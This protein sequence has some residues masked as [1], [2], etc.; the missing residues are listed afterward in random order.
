MARPEP[1]AALDHRLNAWR[2]DLADRR[3]DGRVTAK[4]FVDGEP[5]FVIEPLVALYEAPDH[6]SQRQSE[7]LFGEG[8]RVFE[9]REGWAWV[10]SAR[11]DYVGYADEGSIAA[12][13][14]PPTTHMVSVPSGA[15]VFADPDIKSECRGCIPL[16]GWLRARSETDRFLELADDCGFVHIRHVAPASHRADDF[17]AVAE[18]FVGA[19]YLWGGNSR[20]GIDCSGLVQMAMLAVGLVCPRDSDMQAS[21]VGTACEIPAA[22]GG[23][24]NGALQRGDLVFWRGHVG[25]LASETELL[26]A[27]AHHMA[28]VIEPLAEAVAR[29]DAAAGAVTAV[30]RVE[31]AL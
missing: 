26:H 16:N 7:L 24:G 17:V 3:L 6:T 18:A 9:R 5:A 31:P 13:E 21:D 23:D 19:P 14:P 1:G 28:T 25:I 20:A 2:P 29:I 4:R 11:D 15:L 27:N 8:V 30:R 22:L 12:G 10:Q